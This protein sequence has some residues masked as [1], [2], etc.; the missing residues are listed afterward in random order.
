[1]GDQKETHKQRR[2]RKAADFNL[3]RMLANLMPEDQLYNQFI[4][5]WEKYKKSG[6]KEDRPSLPLLMLSVKWRDENQ[7]HSIEDA[8]N[9]TEEIADMHMIHQEMKDINKSI[10]DD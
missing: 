1:M 8:M 6:N 3:M 9:N 10:N 5:G 2:D 4:E 7:G